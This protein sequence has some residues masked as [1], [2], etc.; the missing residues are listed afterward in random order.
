MVNWK[1]W[2]NSPPTTND[3]AFFFK[4]KIMLYTH[5]NSVGSILF[6]ARACARA[7]DDDVSSRQLGKKNSRAFLLGWNEHLSISFAPVRMRIAID[8]SKWHWARHSPVTILMTA[9]E[10]AYI[11]VFTRKAA[12]IYSSK[13]DAWKNGWLAAAQTHTLYSI[14]RMNNRKKKTKF[15]TRPPQTL[16]AA[17]MSHWPSM[18]IARYASFLVMREPFN[19]YSTYIANAFLRLSEDER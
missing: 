5:E 7:R 19:M 17:R 8:T 9:S 2:T 1:R 4:Q 11:I 14:K 15:R 18:F 10:K 13:Y 12:Y 6:V 16:I 3:D